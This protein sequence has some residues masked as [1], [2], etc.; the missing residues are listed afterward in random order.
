MRRPILPFL[1]LTLLLCS[2]SAQALS[3]EETDVGSGAKS[4]WLFQIP[5]ASRTLGG[6]QFWGDVQFFH[7][8]HIQRNTFTDH[9]RLLDGNDVRHAYGTLEECRAALDRIRKERKLPPMSGQ[10]VVLLHGMI[11][12]SKSMSAMAETLRGAGYEVFPIDY[13]ST[14]VSIPEA[15]EYLDS[16][17][18][19]L[20]GLDEIN[21]VV[22]SMGGLVVRAY[23]DQHHDPRLRRMVMLGVPNRGAE[24]ADLLRKNV[25]FRVLLG[26]AGQQLCT[27]GL[28]TRLPIPDFEFAVIAGGRGTPKG[29]NPLIP[30]DDD[31]TVSVKCTRLPGAADFA[32]VPCLHTFLMRDKQA[33]DYTLRFLQTGRLREDGAPQPI[34]RT[35]DAETDATKVPAVCQ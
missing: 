8:W 11:R 10:G 14:R 28:I 2:G 30:G 33:A 12:S 26:E 22:H 18:S 9:Y 23:L 35:T 20:D 1:V 21:F 5:F 16:I 25:F 32:T 3:Q 31:G 13:P 27:D 15:A 24:M 29:W 19:H 34:L 7:D 4:S 6:R 17:V